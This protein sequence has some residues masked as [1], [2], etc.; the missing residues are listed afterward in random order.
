MPLLPFRGSSVSEIYVCRCSFY[1]KTAALLVYTVVLILFFI[2]YLFEIKFK[3]YIVLFI[4]F[5]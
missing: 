4:L 2:A 1:I 3:E 5:G